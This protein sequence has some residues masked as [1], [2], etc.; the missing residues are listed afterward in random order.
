MHSKCRAI[1]L[2]FSAAALGLT[3]FTAVAAQAEALSDGGKAGLFLVG[4]TGGQATLGAK[5]EAVQQGTATLLAPGRV[6]ILCTKGTAKGE[7]ENDTKAFV[8]AEFSGCTAWQP[9]ALGATHTTAVKCTVKEPIK[10]AKSQALPK[11]HEAA[12]YVL[13]EE[14]GEFFTTIFLEGPECPVTKENK[15]TGAVH[16]VI[17]SNDSAEPTLLLSEETAKLF[18]PTATTGTHLKFGLFE[19]YIDANLKVKLTDAAHTGKT[20][21]VSEPKEAISLSDGGKAGLFL[22]IEGGGAPELGTTFNANQIGTT[23][24]L[25]PGRVDIL[26]TEGIANGEFENDT[27]AFISAEFSGCTTWNPVALGATHTTAVKCTVKEPIVVA[28]SQALPKEHEAASYVLIEEEG[29]IL[30]TI[31]LEGPECPLTKE[32]KVT[33]A[34]HAW[35]HGHGTSNPTLLFSEEITKLFQPTGSTGT[36]LKFGALNA[37]IDAEAEVKHVESAEEILED[38]GKGGEFLIN[39]EA[40]LAKSGVTFQAN[41]V[42]TAALLIP[43]RLDILCTAATATGE[44]HNQADAVATVKITGCTVWLPVALGAVHTEKISCTVKEPIE[45]T[46]LAIPKLHRGESYLLLQSE[47]PAFTTYFLEGAACPLTKENKI[48]GSFH[49]LIDN[50]DTT[51]PLLLF[52]EEIAKLFQPTGATGNHLRLGTFEVYIDAHATVKLTDASHKGQTL[53]VC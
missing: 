40:A 1:A 8:S 32:N 12:P 41:Q 29:E 42:G 5:F 26:C 10:V 23:T 18:Q 13:I 39:K 49:L 43:G 38:G 30:T 53:G 11:E 35:I 6:D 36:R 24:L 44:F 31:F 7:F 28:K 21:G 17:D 45:A 16:A 52:G 50:N 20:L 37:Y 27:K 25:V 9:V 33:G 22:G 3:A 15:V 48:T 51:E 19:S 46:A 4:K 47:G 34:V 2:S 14:E